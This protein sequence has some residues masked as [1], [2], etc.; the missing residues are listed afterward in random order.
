MIAADWTTIMLLFAAYMVRLTK[1]YPLYDKNVI[2]LYG[3]QW[4]LNVGWNLAFFNKKNPG[5]GFMVI[6]VLWLLIGYFTLRFKSKMRY[7]TLFI[8]PY[9]IWMTIATSLNGYIVIFN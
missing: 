7:A 2:V 6:V 9:L 3:I 1:I 8:I 4:V 5:I